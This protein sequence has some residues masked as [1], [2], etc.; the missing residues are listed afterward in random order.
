MNKI[1]I[2]PRQK[3]KLDKYE[4]PHKIKINIA[5]LWA[6]R[7][8]N[9]VVVMPLHQLFNLIMLRI[10]SIIVP[11]FI[12][13]GLAWEFATGTVLFID[14]KEITIPLVTTLYFLITYINLLIRV[15][16][17]E[18]E[19]MV[20]FSEWALDIWQGERDSRFWYFAAVYP[21]I[22]FG[23]LVNGYYALA[24]A[25]FVALCFF[26]IYFNLV[27]QAVQKH[28]KDIEDKIAALA[29]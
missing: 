22:L 12:I 23:L 27:K 11:L 8:R 5:S 28:I 14:Y 3:E 24:V 7:D 13:G 15:S 26:K 18:K 20:A 25:V 9:R 4:L 17:A 6:T 2:T 19:R 10:A 21:L 16:L 29:A 1:T